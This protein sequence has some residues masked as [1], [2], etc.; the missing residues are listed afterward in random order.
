MI[1]VTAE[2]APALPL[3]WPDGPLGSPHQLPPAATTEAVVVLLTPQRRPVR[4]LQL[5]VA[6][7]PA[8]STAVSTLRKSNESKTP[9]ALAV[10]R[11]SPVVA[12]FT[13]SRFD[14]FRV[15]SPRTAVPAHCTSALVI[16][17]VPVSSTYTPDQSPPA[18]AGFEDVSVMGA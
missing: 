14:P 9:W 17:A 12:R 10:A 5:N 13:D 2:Q 6:V 3:P 7:V 16:V 15:P 1:D 8:V 18:G 4:L 11:F